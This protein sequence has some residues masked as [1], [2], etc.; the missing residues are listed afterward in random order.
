[1]QFVLVPRGTFWMSVNARN[2]QKQAEIPH[3]FY[4]GAYEVTQGQWQAVMGNNPSYFSRTGD[5]SGWVK[6]IPEA[7]FK[8]FPVENVSWEDVQRFVKELNRREVSRGGWVYRLPSEVEWEYCCR[9][10]A[11]SREDCSFDFYFK[12]R[13]TDDLSSDQANFNGNLPAGKARKGKHLQRTTEVGSYPP[14]ALGLYDMHGNVWEWCREW[15]EEGSSRVL[16]GGCW[17]SQAWNCRAMFRH[18]R[19]PAERHQELGFRLAL[20]PAGSQAEQ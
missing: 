5:G 7:R 18:R 17:S 14:N 2:A 9:G 12:G 3:D 11:T 19:A 8:E 4:M 10:G 13:L 6:D 15:Y 20:V 1:M 16:R